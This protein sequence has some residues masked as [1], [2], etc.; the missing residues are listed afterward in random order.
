MFINRIL[1]WDSM[2]KKR[3]IIEKEAEEEYEFIPPEFD[4]KEFI[5]KD[6]YG[7]KV[8]LAVTVLS[9]VFGILCSCVQKAFSGF[10]L[11]LGLAL[12]FLAMFCL[13]KILGFFKL[14]SE[15]LESKTMVGNYIL[16]LLLGLGVWILMVNAP[17]V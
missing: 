16:F 3:R 12:L 7:T 11:Y 14:K 13:P 17:F 2:A 6:I 5:L 15:Y 1:M 4:E 10:G 8:L 9:I